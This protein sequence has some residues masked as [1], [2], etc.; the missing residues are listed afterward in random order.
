MK[1]SVFLSLMLSVSVLA[2]CSAEPA[3]SKNS[4]NI[5]AAPMPTEYIQQKEQLY[6]DSSHIRKQDYTPI[7]YSSPTGMWFPYM[8]Y[9]SYMQGKTAEEFRAAA[10]EMYKQA[11]ENGVNTI[12]VHIHPCGDAYYKSDIFPKGTYLDG[13][14]D[15]LEIMLEEAHRL[16]LSVHA[17]I[18]PLRCQTTEQMERLP[19]TYIVKQ[20]TQ[21][22]TGSLVNIVGD[23][24]YLNPAYEEVIDLVCRCADEL[25][26]NYNIDGLHIDDYFYP[27]TSADFDSSAFETSGHSDLSEWRLEN[28]SRLVHALYESVKRVDSRIQFGISPQGNINANYSSQYA[29]VKLWCSSVGYCDYIVPQIYYGF[30]NEACPFRETLAQWEALVTNKNITLVIGLAAYKLGAED[31]WAGAAGELEWIENPDIIAQQIECV[32][33]SSAAG[34][35]LYY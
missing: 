15:P 35:A 31:K 7:N 26:R 34:Y 18:N 28:C 8:D 13:D 19:E 24:Y 32:R 29:D 17:W 3:I 23:R 27:T 6:L 21:T 30:N 5:S 33:S 2:A 20:W 4:S 16:N 14:Y 22:R 1:L 11:K 25:V 12:Y 9:A 10:A